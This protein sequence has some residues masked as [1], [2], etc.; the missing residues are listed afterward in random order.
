[1]ALK[2]ATEILIADDMESLRLFGDHVFVAPREEVFDRKQVSLLCLYWTYF[3][4]VFYRTLG[5]GTLSAHAVH[6]VEHEGTLSKDGGDLRTH[7]LERVK[8]FLYDQDSTR[9]SKID[10]A[11]WHN[12]PEKFKVKYCRDLNITKYVEFKHAEDGVRLRE[13]ALAGV[14][15]TTDKNIVLWV[16]DDSL[17][18]KRDWYE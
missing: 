6:V 13:M 8:I 4:L 15:K 3:L 14:E 17:E 1:M 10:P 12:E 9:R 7:I 2:R 5:A 11:E 18:G 16:K